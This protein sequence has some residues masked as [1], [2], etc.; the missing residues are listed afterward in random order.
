MNDDLRTKSGY[1]GDKAPLHVAEQTARDI[2]RVLKDA[3]PPGWGF[4][5]MMFSY[6]E[7]GHTTYISSA[8]RE[9]VIKAL[10]EMIEK[11]K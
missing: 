11:L 4:T 5:L 3:M 9:D 8:K 7:N 6:G 2:G 1:P 10:A